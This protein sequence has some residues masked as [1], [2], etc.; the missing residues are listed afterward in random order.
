MRDHEQRTE[1]VQI[2][3]PVICEAVAVILFIAACAVWI[4]ISATPMPA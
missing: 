2:A 1:I 3:V 4:I